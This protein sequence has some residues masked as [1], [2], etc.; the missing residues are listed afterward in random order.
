MSGLIPSTARKL[1]R[2]VSKVGP[3]AAAPP[4]IAT[5]D[6]ARIAMITYCVRIAQFAPIIAMVKRTASGISPTHSRTS[7]NDGNTVT[8]ASVKPIT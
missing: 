2:S 3:L 7:A 5:M 1:V 8:K 4:R 6:S